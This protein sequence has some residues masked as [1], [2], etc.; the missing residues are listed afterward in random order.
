MAIVYIMNHYLQ[1]RLN[2]DKIGSEST[3]ISTYFFMSNEERQNN[4]K[5]SSKNKC[6][7]HN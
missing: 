7:S 3:E 6:S 4:G 2:F 1:E 5:K